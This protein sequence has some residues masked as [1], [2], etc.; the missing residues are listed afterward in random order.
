[1]W[2]WPPDPAVFGRLPDELDRVVAGVLGSAEVVPLLAVEGATERGYATAATL[3]REAAIAGAVDWGMAIPTGPGPTA[4]QVAAAIAV[5]EAALGRRLTE[6]QAAGVVG[7]CASPRA[8]E[9]L[10]GL[11][12]VG[13]TTALEAIADAFGAAGW[14]VIG[15]ATSG[16][17]ARTLGRGS[18]PAGG[19]G[20]LPVVAVRS[21]KPRSG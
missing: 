12:G 15:T 1:M 6:G 19:D 11:A 18:E 10:I 17:A 21:R 20:R 7:V 14:K 3:A 2:W 16:Q 13:K 8:L 5:K 4:E 9:L